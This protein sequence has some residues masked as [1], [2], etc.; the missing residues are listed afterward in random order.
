M[1]GLLAWPRDQPTRLGQ[2]GHLSDQNGNRQSV[3]T[4]YYSVH[5]IYS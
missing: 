1:N 4:K 5:T 3:E 2:Y